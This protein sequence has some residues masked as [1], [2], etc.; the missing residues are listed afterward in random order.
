MP[1]GVRGCWVAP[2]AHT[3]RRARIAGV[4]TERCCLG[5][6]PGSGEGRIGSDAG[7]WRSA[8]PPLSYTDRPRLDHRVPER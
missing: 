8:P 2:K 7:H 6:W 5:P 4:S 3:G 1:R